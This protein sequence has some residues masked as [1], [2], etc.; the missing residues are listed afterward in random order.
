[1]YKENI[2]NINV[3]KQYYKKQMESQ[4]TKGHSEKYRFKT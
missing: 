3:N 1:M 4:F 2:L